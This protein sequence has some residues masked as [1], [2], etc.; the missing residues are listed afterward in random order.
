MWINIVWF[1]YFEHN[2]SEENMNFQLSLKYVS[3][4]S[5]TWGQISI[6]MSLNNLFCV[7]QIRH[8]SSHQ[9]SYSYD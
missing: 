5:K 1:I 9:Y 4:F 8:T 2:G 3:F 6:M 7:P